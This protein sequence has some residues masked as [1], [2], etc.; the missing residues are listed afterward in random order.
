[1]GG[2]LKQGHVL[3][4]RTWDLKFRG[5]F[6]VLVSWLLSTSILDLM[7][8]TSFVKMVCERKTEI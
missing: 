1:M 7:K 4:L 8:I 2:H 3:Q 5:S 6:V